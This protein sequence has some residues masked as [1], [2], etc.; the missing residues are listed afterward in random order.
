MLNQSMNNSNTLGPQQHGMQN[1]QMQSGPGPMYEHMLNPMNGNMKGH[2][3]FIYMNQQHPHP[4][5][6]PQ[7]QYMPSRNN[8]SVN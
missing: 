8:V 2:S 6:M 1:L 4:L 5:N 7:N 3:D